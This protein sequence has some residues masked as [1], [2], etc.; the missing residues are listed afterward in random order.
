M[1][2]AMPS[3]PRPWTVLP[4]DRLEK[5]EENF[6]AVSGAL[7]R[8]SM[9]RRMCIVC[10]SD[11][12]LVFHNAIPLQ[13]EAMA[14]VGAFGRP[15]I[16]IVPNRFHRL[17]IHAWK[18][19]FPQLLV[20]C[21]PQARA[22]VSQVVSV[23]GDW[24]ALPRD[25]AM[26]VVPFTGSR[27]GEAALVVRSAGGQRV[28]LLFADTVMNIPD[29][30]GVGGL[31]LRLLGSS[32]GPKVTPFARLLTIRDASAVAADLERLAAI[33]GLARLV[34]THGDIVGEDAPAVL[35]EV[36]SCLR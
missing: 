24:S 4:H 3:S 15:A 5:L 18:Q 8:G 11:G 13:E 21:P 1:R 17:D 10:L 34:P 23:D 30:P 9:N 35:R 36:A 14:Q 32:G 20:F 29:Q 12:R 27:W 16:L 2:V 6:W 22:H 31:V 26:E 19:R 25:P 33:P 7:P 28:S